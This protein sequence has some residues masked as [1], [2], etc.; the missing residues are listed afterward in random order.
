MHGTPFENK[1][2]STMQATPKRNFREYMK[3]Q[4][5]DLNQ[6]PDLLD[7]IRK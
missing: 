2:L 3:N 1:K 5:L 6:K 7:A 4:N